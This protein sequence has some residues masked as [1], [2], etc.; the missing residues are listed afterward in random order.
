MFA[1]GTSLIVLAALSALIE[2]LAALFRQV[3]RGYNEGWNAFWADAAVR[4]GP[5]YVNAD[6]LIANNYPPLSFHFVGLIGRVV[7]D[8]VIAGRLVSLASFVVLLAAAYLF[9]RASGCARRVALAGMAILLATFAYFAQNYVAMNDPQMLAHALMLSGLVVLW[10]F[11]FSR[12]AVVT[13]ALLILLAGF[14]KHLLIPL[15]LALTLWIALHRRGNLVLWLACLAIGIPLG[16]WVCSSLYPPFISELLSPRAYSLHAT[17][18]ATVHALVRFMPLILCGAIPLVKAIRSGGRSAISPRMTLVL[19]YAA[20]SLVIGAIA[21][22]GDGV[23]RNAFF[24]LLIALSLFAAF[25]LDRMLEHARENRAPHL[26]P[27]PATLAFLGAALV[28][29]ALAQTPRTLQD[30]RELD[31]LERDTVAMVEM[32]QRLGHGQAAC[33]TLVLCY[34]ARDRFT[35]DFYNYGRR[36]RTGTASVASCEAALQRGQFPVLQV[37][38]DGRHPAGTRLWPC[39]PAIHQYYTEAFRSRAGILLVPKERLARS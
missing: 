38:P 2:P 23:T 16:L 12:M 28:A 19:L 6:Q 32:I 18:Y 1:A 3:S 27:A 29:Y 10:R 37:E 34:W 22:G 21:A 14:T 30:L 7:G 17:V 5:L 26:Q 15:P 35:V 20:L 31:A 8:N 24:D 36:L 11:D 33:E 25:G 13:A 4:N 39:T 9:L